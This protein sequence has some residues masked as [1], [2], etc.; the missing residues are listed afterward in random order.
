MRLL[1]TA[2]VTSQADKHAQHC[3]KG[4]LRERLVT[5]TD[6]DTDSGEIK[7]TTLLYLPVGTDHSARGS[8]ALL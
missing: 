4:D 3:V 7:N 1:A 5:L 2:A 6:L 8:V